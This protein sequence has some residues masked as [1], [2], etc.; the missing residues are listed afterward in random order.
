MV[1][2]GLDQEPRKSN[3]LVDQG[4]GLLNERKYEAAAAHFCILIDRMN[5]NDPV[6]KTSLNRCKR[7]YAIALTEGVGNYSLAESI[8]VPLKE[9]NPHWAEPSVS[10]GRLYEKMGQT[11]K[12]FA[13]FS[14]ART[15]F[16]GHTQVEG[17]FDHFLSKNPKYKSKPLTHQYNGQQTGSVIAGP[18]LDALSHRQQNRHR[19]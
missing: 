10:L 7:G 19:R 12:A 18:Q 8:L 9:N 17:S 11:D 16:P 4:Y 15:K 5:P 1:E 3:P 2:F 13:I 6:D 14:E